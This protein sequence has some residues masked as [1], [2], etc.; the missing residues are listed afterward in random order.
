MQ[1]QTEAHVCYLPR[2][3]LSNSPNVLENCLNILENVSS[4]TFSE[5]A[6]VHD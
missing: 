6:R 1:T 4:K 3:V 2:G 5:R